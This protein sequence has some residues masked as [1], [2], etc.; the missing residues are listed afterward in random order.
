MMLE[1]HSEVDPT[2]LYHWFSIMHPALGRLWYNFNKYL[3]HWGRRKY[4]R[5]AR[6]KRQAQEYVRYLAKTNP[7]LFIGSLE[8]YDG[9]RGRSRMS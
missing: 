4:K 2:P 8:Q 7:P 1:R 3:E 5:F 6:H 9:P